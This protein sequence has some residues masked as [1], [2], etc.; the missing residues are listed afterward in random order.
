MDRVVYEKWN[1]VHVSPR[2]T[3][4]F[5][6][7]LHDELEIVLIDSGPITAYVD[8]QEYSLENGA[9]CI[10]FP[11]QLHSYVDHFFAN[12]KNNYIMIFS[13]DI[14][15]SFS[16]DF[17][18]K[19][20]KNP[21]I[22]DPEILNDVR[23]YLKEAC[24][25]SRSKA[26]FSTEALNAFSVLVLSKIL[27]CLSLESARHLQKNISADIFTYCNK[28]FCENIS[29]ETISKELNVSKDHISRL[30]RE[31]F[32]TSFK[33]YI[34]G[35]RVGRAKKLLKTTNNSI[36]EIASLSGF[37]TIRSFNRTFSDITGLSPSQY[38]NKHSN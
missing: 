24:E 28:N 6:P 18:D 31:K 27:P 29:L 38:R 23:K 34:S 37:N 11:N 15:R 33:T 10:M 13:S 21:V 32:H 2:S 7:H 12:E 1:K 4:G 19:I 36:T 35:L 8:D 26:Q 9:L 20:P 3:L 25:F 30:F 5:A 16:V 22:T 17:D 14:L